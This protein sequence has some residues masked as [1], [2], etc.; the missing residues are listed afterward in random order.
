MIGGLSRR[1][2][3]GGRRSAGSI[4]DFRVVAIISVRTCEPYLERC[5]AGMIEQGIDI[6]VID[7][8]AS[9]ETKA[10]IE[11]H[12]DRG[13]VH[14]EHF[15]YP[16][17]FDWVGI[18]AL[19]ERLART[20]DADWVMLWDSDEI[21]EA[22]AGFG[23][24]RE[25]L[26]RVDREGY[27]AVN[28]SEFVFLPT[29]REQDFEGRDFVS[30]LPLYYFFEPRPNHRVTAWKKGPSGVDLQQS[31]GHAVSFKGIRIYPEPFALRHYLFLSWRHG[32]E[33]YV[34]REFSADELKRGWSVERAQTTD[35]TLRL[36]SLDEVTRYDEDGQWNRTAPQTRHLCFD[37]TGLGG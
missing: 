20:L 10:I 23:S 33:K 21:R 15:P 3:F 24:L 8:D 19:K 13:I 29:D 1:F 32:V 12:R 18:L 17:Y 34:R 27:N 5:F 16:G 26:F 25:A 22:P 4:D 7:N 2:G 28:F 9:P 14:V 36:P 30:G 37:Y 6:C 31:A 11:R 35:K